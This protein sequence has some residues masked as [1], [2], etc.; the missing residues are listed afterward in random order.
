VAAGT[1]T[2]GTAGRPIATGTSPATATTTWGSGLLFPSSPDQVDTGLLTRTKSRPWRS[3]A[4]SRCGA[5]AGS[6]S[7]MAKRRFRHCFF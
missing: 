2:P 5:G 4:K 1:T 6:L 7:R 3:G